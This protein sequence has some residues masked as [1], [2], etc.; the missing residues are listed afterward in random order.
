MERELA[1]KKAGLSESDIE[2]INEEFY[3]AE[4]TVLLADPDI[5]GLE[6]QQVSKR[7][8]K[9]LA[10]SLGDLPTEKP[11]GYRRFMAVQLN[12]TATPAIRAVKVEQ[13]TALINKY[14]VDVMSYLEHGLNMAHFKSSKTFDS[15]FES[16][17]QLR[18]I[19]GHNKNEYPE[20]AHQ[21]GGTGTM[22]T[23]EM[24]E[25]WKDSGTDF[26]NLGR[27]SWV[28]FGTGDYIS[29]VVSIYGVGRRR[30]EGWG[31]VYQQHLRYIQSHGFVLS[32][33]ELFCEDLLRQL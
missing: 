24:I 13:C 11:D 1:Q 8:E 15:F 29:R 30:T 10:P 14:D 20:S 9:Y 16:E 27:W 5:A 28:T 7:L 32:P 2:R 12:G 26:R 25:Y 3:E 19:T 17:V 23:N 33:Y 18:S 4:E 6:E 21:Q 31:R 22:A